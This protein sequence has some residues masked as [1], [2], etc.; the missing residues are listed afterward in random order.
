[1]APIIPNPDKIK[2]FPTEAAFEAWLAANHARETELW[3][4][5]HKK[6]SGVPTVTYAQALDVALCWGW[7]DGIRKSFDEISFL[8]RYTPRKARSVWSQINRDHIARLTT[9][10]RMTPHGQRHVDAAKADGR[11]EAAYAPIRSATE[12]TLPADLRAAIEANPRARKTFQTLGRQNL[13]ALA[14]RM[15]N[16]K[17]PAG[18]AKKIETLVAMLARGETIVPEG[19]R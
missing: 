2:S 17:T 9:A 6:D 18:R 19:R 12:D 5:I 8:Q 13:F 15:N 7:I 3:L 14:F 16:V 1:M 10:G 11:W 4:K